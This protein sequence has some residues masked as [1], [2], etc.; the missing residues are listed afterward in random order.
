[1]RFYFTHLCARQRC[2]ISAMFRSIH[3]RK[4]GQMMH[5]KT[6]GKTLARGLVKQRVNV[7]TPIWLRRI[8]V[9]HRRFTKNWCRNRVWEKIFIASLSLSFQQN[10]RR[11]LYIPLHGTCLED[12]QL[13]DRTYLITGI[14]VHCNIVH[15][16][17]R[18]ICTSPVIR[19]YGFWR[20]GYEHFPLAILL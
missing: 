9:G 12:F 15:A 18:S 13:Q 17:Y 2:G 20:T 6:L 7:P 11:L 3:S 4:L 14:K 16:E 19:N 5:I 1:M 8:Y 10:T